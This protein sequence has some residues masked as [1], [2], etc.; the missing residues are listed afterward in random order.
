[1]LHYDEMAAY[2]PI[3]LKY[4]KDLQKYYPQP[5]ANGVSIAG[6]EKAKAGGT[7]LANP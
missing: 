1:V 3:A 5:V 2:R 6:S 7:T 4:H